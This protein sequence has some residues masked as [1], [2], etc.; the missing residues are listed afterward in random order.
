MQMRKRNHKLRCRVCDRVLPT[1]RARYCG[2]RCRAKL[3]QIFNT[4]PQVVSKNHEHQEV[5]S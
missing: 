2:E 1:T 3:E 5:Y 4:T